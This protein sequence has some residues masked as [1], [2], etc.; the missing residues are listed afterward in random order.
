MKK[1]DYVFGTLRWLLILAALTAAIIRY[2][3]APSGVRWLVVIAIGL[4]CIGFA[5]SFSPLLGGKE[6]K[7]A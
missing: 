7:H 1:Q 5:D 2:P 3:D 6:L 4:S